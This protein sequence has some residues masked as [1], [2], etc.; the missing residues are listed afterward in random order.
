MGRQRPEKGS[1]SRWSIRRLRA[2]TS[3][4]N[5][6]GFEI[7]DQYTLAYVDETSCLQMGSLYNISTAGTGCTHRR[8]WVGSDTV[9]RQALERVLL[10]T[11]FVLAVACTRDDQ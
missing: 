2:L 4:L 11:V 1:H 10:D 7:N 3:S 9:A 5:Q 6:G 8:R